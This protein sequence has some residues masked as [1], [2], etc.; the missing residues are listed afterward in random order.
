[1]EGPRETKNNEYEKVILL[2]NNIFRTNKGYKPTMQYEFPILLN[3]DNR[4]NMRIIVEDN[5]PVSCVNFVQREILV[6]GAKIDVASIGAVCTNKEYRGKGYSSLLLE[7]VEKKMYEDGVDLL[8]VSGTR[9][10][11]QR[12]G[13]TMTRN[14]LSYKV[15]PEN[16]TID[17]K[18]REYKN[19][20]LEKI[21]PLYNSLST[22]FYRS[23]NDFKKLI[24]SAVFP[25][26]T[27]TYKRCVIVENEE[28]TGYI[29]IRIINED[30]LRGEVVELFGSPNKIYNA[31]KYLAYENKLEFIEYK[32]NTQDKINKLS[33]E[34]QSQSCYQEGTLKIINFEKFMCNLKPYF[35]QYIDRTILNEL[36]FKVEQIGEIEENK[37]E[38]GVNYKVLDNNEDGFKLDVKEDILKDIELI[39]EHRIYK[40][41][42]KNQVIEINNVI[43]LN[44]LVFEGAESLKIDFKD[45]ETLRKFI[46][47]VFPIPFVYVAN[48]NYQ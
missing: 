43:D 25:W 24:D 3:K 8:L 39:K 35:L 7:D 34:V 45:K 16:I 5:K 47:T 28:V 13:C 26:G 38:V 14:F 29:F 22:R 17:F 20:D 18:I 21:V 41:I 42:F 30:I 1:M 12:R 19:Q 33:K 32:V 11:Y 46:T 2:I 31:L 36:V 40:F 6:E 15:L 23:Y 48:L 10:L 37:K 4:E 44:K 9:A 27:F